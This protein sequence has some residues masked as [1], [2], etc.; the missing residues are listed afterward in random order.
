MRHS[1]TNPRAGEHLRQN[2]KHSSSHHFAQIRRF[3]HQRQQL[4]QTDRFEQDWPTRTRGEFELVHRGLACHQHGS[5]RARRFALEEIQKVA[6]LMRFELERGNV[7]GF[8]K[9]LDYH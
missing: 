8:A 5:D 7:D 1:N 6:A 3:A 4:A 9:L 2:S